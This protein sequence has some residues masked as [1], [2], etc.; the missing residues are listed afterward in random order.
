MMIKNQLIKPLLLLFLAGLLSA[1]DDASGIK[2]IKSDNHAQ[3]RTV[4]NHYFKQSSVYNPFR[5]TFM[6]EKGSN[7]T[8]LEPITEQTR[9]TRL[10][11]EKRFLKFIQGVNQDYLSEQDKLSVE[12][13]IYARQLEIESFDY[14]MHLTPINQMSGIHNLVAQLASGQSAQPF[15]TVEDYREFMA[16]VTGYIKWLESAENAMRT[17]LEQNV[18]HPEVIVKKLIPQFAYHIKENVEESIYAKPILNSRLSPAELETIK[19]DYLAFIEQQVIP[20]HQQ[21]H[22]FLLN[23]YLPKARK[24]FGISGM[25]NG[26]AWYKYLIKANTT[27][28]VEPAEVHALGLKEV[29]RIR[30][31]MTQVKETVNFDGDLQEFFVHLRTSDEFY[32]TSREEL[33]NAY[34]QVREQINQLTPKLFNIFP[35]ADYEVRLTED[36]RAASSAGAQYQAP[37]VDGSRPGIFYI[38]GY[39]LK[40]QPKFLVET[41]SIHEASPGH[42]FQSSIQQELVDL[43]KFR[44]FGSYSV[45]SEG[46]ALY[47]ESLGKEMGLFTDPMM[48]YGRLVDEQLRAMRLVV[49]TGLHAMDWTRQQAIQYMLDNSSMNETDVTAEV[50][51]YMAIPGQALSYKLGQFKIQELRDFATMQLGDK[52]DVR[53]FHTQVLKDGALPMPILE[54]KIKRWVQS[55]VKTATSG[56]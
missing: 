10:E 4:F 3:M 49:D 13:F 32:F 40:A 31:E 44:R 41:L 5:A 28:E 50:E 18:I 6:G 45:Y 39:N 23:E 15:D 8:F 34:D 52:F 54:R 1:C 42:H 7:D 37:S 29:Q 27:L 30:D 36:F 56:T 24:D 47:A 38:N 55:Q 11:F 33:V 46:W 51:R 25:P 20:A 43:P 14:P 17:G 48:W 53:E 2:K 26:L 16:R 9:N 12:A 35:K 19:A 22:D 21:M